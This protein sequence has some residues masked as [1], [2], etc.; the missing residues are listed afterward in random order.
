MRIVE[1]REATVPFASAL[2]N[3]AIDFSAMT[4]SVVAVL[5]D[6]VRDGRPV[7]GYGFCSNGRYAQGGILRER[8]IPRVLAAEPGALL[9]DAG[10]NLDPLR[11]WD[12]A[13][14]NEKPGG[15]G[16]RAVAMAAGRWSATASAPTAAT[17]RAASCASA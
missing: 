3:A 13:M 17:P 4:I 6:A 14:R 8:L 1:L 12:A 5:T 10:S 7:V 9:D 2:R 11:V 16:D 15:H